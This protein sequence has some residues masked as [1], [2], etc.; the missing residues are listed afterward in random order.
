MKAW[1][2]KCTVVVD[3]SQVKRRRP[4][5]SMPTPKKSYWRQIPN[6]PEIAK[7]KLTVPKPKAKI[8]YNCLPHRCSLGW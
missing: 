4:K 3:I 6:T 5:P 7:T 8:L 1:K 2:Q